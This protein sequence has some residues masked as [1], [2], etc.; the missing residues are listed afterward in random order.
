ME[1]MVRK[2]EIAVTS[3]YSFSHHVFHS[4][5]S[6]VHQNAA[7]CGNWLTHSQTSPGFYVSAVQVF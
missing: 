3:D 1:N 5:I 2:G 6:L 7:L 4:Y